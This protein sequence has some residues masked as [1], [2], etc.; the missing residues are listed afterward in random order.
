ME[1]KTEKFLALVRIIK[2]LDS[3]KTFTS[4][5]GLNFVG[6]NSRGVDIIRCYDELAETAI[7]LAKM[8]DIKKKEN[9]K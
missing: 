6:Y 7:E 2:M 4:E 5:E 9:Q 8:F 3:Y 1:I